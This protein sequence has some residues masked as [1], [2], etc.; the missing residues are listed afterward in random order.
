M[1]TIFIPIYFRMQARNILRTGTYRTLIADD[2]VRVVI[3]VPPFKLE[4]YRK[5]FAAP[6][7]LFEGV[8]EPPSFFSRLDAF[9]DH[10]SL[11]YLSTPTG[12]FFRKQWILREHHRPLRYAFSMVVLSIIGTIPLLQRLG[13]WLDYQLVRESWYAPYFEKYKPDVIFAPH[14]ISKVERSLLRQ[15]KR[16]GVRTVGM[17]NSWDNITLGKYPFR[18][19]SDKL[20]VHNELIKNEAVK[21]LHYHPEN[22]FIAGMPHFDHY[23]TNA[24]IGREEFCTRFGIDPRKR[25]VLFTSISSALN[26]TEWQVLSMLTA[27]IEDGRLPKDLILL[28]RH[29]P[30]SNM[31]V[32][33]LKPS[34]H[35]IFD[36]SK[37]LF[38][39]G[40]T[41]SEILRSDMEHL[42]NSLYHAEL[43]ITTASTTSI[44][45]AAFDKPSVNLAFDGWEKPPFHRSVRR[46]YEPSHD[47]YQ[48]IVKSGGVRIVYSFD[49]LVKNI[50]AYLAD[51]SRDREGRARIIREQCYKLD[52]K[53]GERVG[54]YLLSQ[55]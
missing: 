16:R 54:E 5:E 21:Y 51:S 18:L 24:R 9:F 20:I 2:T 29:H 40:K 39:R 55:A 44:D 3:F 38:E 12:R 11:F 47:H 8:A 19:L 48:A 36:N 25:I 32:G 10:L 45:A 30:V 27:A 35:L 34:P 17:I 28:V 50:V 52:G 13:R 6:N 23:V 43:I 15:A 31:L 41:Y 22:I 42:A 26:P 7:V 49:D 53:A 33:D 37:T 14:I 4:E 1:K 46:F